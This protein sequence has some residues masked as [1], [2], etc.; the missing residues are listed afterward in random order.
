MQTKYT[1]RFLCI[2]SFFISS[3]NS[4]ITTTPTQ[5]PTVTNAATLTYTATF[6]PTPTLNAIQQA[7]ATQDAAKTNAPR[8]TAISTPIPHLEPDAKAMIAWEE[9]G[10]SNEFQAFPPSST[11]I[12]EGANA[13]TLSNGKAYNIAG[14]FVFANGENFTHKVY[15]YTIELP[16]QTDRKTFDTVIDTVEYFGGLGLS[17]LENANEIG[18]NSKGASGNSGSWHWTIIAFR[19]DKIG[20]F[21]FVRNKINVT[22][23]IDAINVARVYAKSIEQPTQ[24]C[25]IMS[26]EAIQTEDIP[27]FE[28]EAEG[29]Y[30]QEGRYIT[31]DGTILVGNETQST[32]SMKMGLNGEA[33][34]QDGHLSDMI[35]FFTVEQLELL[36]KQGIQNVQLPTG[37]ME[38]TLTVGGYFSGCETTQTVMWV[39]TEASTNTS[40]PETIPGPEIPKFLSI[41]SG[42]PL[43]EWGNIPVMQDAIAGSEAYGGYLFSIELPVKE[44]VQYYQQVLS[45]SG[46]S[47]TAVGEAK[48]GSIKLI[49]QNNSNQVEI[50]VF[51]IE[52]SYEDP[53]WGFQTPA[54]FVLIVQ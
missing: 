49:F 9:L 23:E 10:L 24:Y 1:I 39:Q 15:G 35:S 17:V 26:T 22:P 8:Q 47:L 12:E 4:A 6:T 40:A 37:S 3:C 13:F 21:V 43:A 2:L 20:A 27:T 50:T 16:T 34:D 38:F 31:L 46:W 42:N 52:F 32:T 7:V 44:V 25:T 45:K 53:M 29:F 18:N 28:F 54:S 30:P 5:P 19:L 48:N 36:A 14:S 51:N 41:P 33:F 11:S